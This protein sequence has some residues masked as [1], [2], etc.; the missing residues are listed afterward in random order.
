MDNM[1][2]QM[3]N[4][5]REMKAIRKNQVEMSEIRKPSNKDEECLWWAY[6]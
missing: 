2:E 4:F 5:I 1:Y 3:E 6:Q